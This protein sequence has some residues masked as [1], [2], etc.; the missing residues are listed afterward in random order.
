MWALPE[1]VLLLATADLNPVAPAAAWSTWLPTIEIPAGFGT[2]WL[3]ASKASVMPAGGV[4]VAEDPKEWEVTSIVLATVVV[5]LGALCVTELEVACPF[6]T[7]M[8]DEVSTPENA[9]SPPADPVEVENV[10]VWLLGSPTVAT[11]L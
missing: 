5:T 1:A 6:S 3:A 11:L 10:Q 7:S 9:A 8:G 4:H 2:A